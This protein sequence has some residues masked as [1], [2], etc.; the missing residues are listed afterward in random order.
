MLDFDRRAAGWTLGLV[1]AHLKPLEAT[2]HADFVVA[3]EFDWNG[4]STIEI[5][6]L[7]ATQAF[8]AGGRVFL[9]LY[10]HRL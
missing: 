3:F 7:G 6:G 2:Q 10:G 5:H 9:N 4:G 1:F 8:R